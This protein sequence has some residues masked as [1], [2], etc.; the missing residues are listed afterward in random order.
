[1]KHI[2]LCI[3][4]IIIS[5][6]SVSAQILESAVEFLPFGGWN[7][8]AMQHINDRIDHFKSMGLYVSGFP[9]YPP[10]SKFEVIGDP[11]WQ[12]LSYG[13]SLRVFIKGGWTISGSI[14]VYQA[15]TNLTGTVIDDE[16]ST[17]EL[18]I[19]YSLPVRAAGGS[20][21][22]TLKTWGNRSNISVGIGAYQFDAYGYFEIG[23]IKQEYKNRFFG[24]DVFVEQKVM[25]YQ[26]L[27]AVVQC[28]FR[29][30]GDGYGE[31]T[32]DYSGV[33]LMAGFFLSQ[34]LKPLED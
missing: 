18:P 19:N 10:S 24:A 32:L 5:V 13:G 21:S 25:L 33:K 29:Y 20:V 31:G 22:K 9:G 34:T 2:S 16:D 14:I 26:Q 6:T 4:F 3:A 12:G 7:T 17:P 30:A 15:K 23:P 27:G 1:M 8:Y 28:G 11:V